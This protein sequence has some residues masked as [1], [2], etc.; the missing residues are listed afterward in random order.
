MF[1]RPPRRSPWPVARSVGLKRS[2]V[3]A[4]RVYAMLLIIFGHSELL[5]G[6]TEVGGIQALQLLLNI[7]SRAAV[8]LFLILAGEHLGPR[9]ARERVPGAA[10]PYVRRLAVLYAIGCLF[11]WLTDFLKLARSRGLGPG[12]AGFLERQATDPIGLLMHGPR[13]HLWFLIVLMLVV[14]AAAVILE[15]ARA[16]WFILGTAALYGIALGLGPY[17]GQVQPD[18]YGWWYELLLQA[19]LFFAIGIVFGLEAQPRSRS[20]VAVGLIAVGLVAHALEVHW[21]SQTYGTWPFRLAMLVGTV[22]YATG[23]AMFALSPGASRLSRWV[24]RFAPY[25]PAVYLTHIFFLE[26]LRPP[27][28]AFPEPLVRVLLPLLTTILAFGSAWFIYWFRHRLRRRRRTE[29][30]PATAA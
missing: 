22:L 15:K 14:I 21:I 16:R 27:R 3:D 20:T 9:L 26:T 18:G 28:D 17:S 24:G 6:K 12:I 2:H 23:V 13:P 8:P 4:F 1:D 29:R 10:W 11:Y 5:L 30:T 25:V 7:V 19:P